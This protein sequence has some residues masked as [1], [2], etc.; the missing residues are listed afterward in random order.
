M[1]GDQ[2]GE[3]NERIEAAVVESGAI[4]RQNDGVIGDT[5]NSKNQ[6]DH[7]RTE[8]SQGRTE[9]KDVPSHGGFRSMHNSGKRSQI[10]RRKVHEAKSQRFR[11]RFPTEPSS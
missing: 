1:E 9:L 3:S 7:D 8:T 4:V 6:K 10:G 5:D 2:N 11:R